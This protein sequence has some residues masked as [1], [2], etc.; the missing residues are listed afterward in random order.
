MHFGGLGPHS[1]CWYPWCYGH[2]SRVLDHYEMFHLNSQD[3]FVS[4]L[5]TNTPLKINME[6]ENTPLDKGKTSTNHQCLGFH[7]S[8]QG[9]TP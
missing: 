4:I 7:V 5:K 1:G 6:P 3:V 9:C 2:T 8:F